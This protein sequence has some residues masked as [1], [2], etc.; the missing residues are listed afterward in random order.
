[1]LSKT[2]HKHEAIMV[3]IFCYIYCKTWPYDE[4]ACCMKRIL[5]TSL[6]NKLD[7]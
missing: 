6:F 7:K 4:T 1:M 5:A 3:A 2:S